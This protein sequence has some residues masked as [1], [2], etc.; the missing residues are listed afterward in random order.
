MYSLLSQFFSLDVLTK[1][2]DG[3]YALV[4]AHHIEKQLVQIVENSSSKPRHPVGILTTE[5]R[6]TW[7]KARERLMKG[8]Y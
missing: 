6:H 3:S 7:Y 2:A 5:H 4:P 8:T 1:L